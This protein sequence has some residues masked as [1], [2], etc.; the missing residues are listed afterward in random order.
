MEESSYWGRRRRHSGGEQHSR[1]SRI[2]NSGVM[3][4][5]VRPNSHSE[6]HILDGDG[7]LFLV[8]A[9]YAVYR[10]LSLT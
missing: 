4:G 10:P 7:D 9:H 3:R 2:V 6:Q 5:S 1:L 8:R